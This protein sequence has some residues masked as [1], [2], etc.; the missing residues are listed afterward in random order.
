MARL[1]SQNEIISNLLDFFRI[2]Q[3]LLDT[4]PGTVARD[5]F[6]DAPSA[7]VARLYREL[8][9]VASVQSLRFALGIDLDKLADNF[10][11]RR[12]KGSKAAG[13]AV[14]TF[15]SLDSDFAINKG[16]LVTARNG[17]TFTVV[18]STIISTVFANQFKATAARLKADLDF[19]GI[20]DQYA[21]EV[22]VEATTAG[23]TGNI[24]KY[25]LSG[26]NIAGINNITNISPIGGGRLPEDDATFRNRILAVFS[27]ANTGTA[28]GYYNAAK[29]DPA[30]IDVIVIEPGDDLMV[31]DGTQ[32]VVSENGTRT[33]TADGTGGKVDVIVFGARF[34]EGLDTFIYRDKSNTGDPT[35]T[36]N[37]YVLGQISGDEN[38]TVTRR[39]LENIK[40]GTLPQQP[41]VNLVQV[42]G[43][44]SGANYVEKSVD[45][46]GRVTGNY[47]LVKD[48][49]AYA[50]SPFGFDRLRWISDRVSDFSEEKTK[51]QFNGQDPVSFTDVLKIGAA[52]QSISIINENSS[53]LPSDRSLIQLAHYPI[54][55]VTRVFNA[56]TGERYVVSNQN[57]DGGATNTTGRIKISGKSLPAVSDTLQVDYVWN[58][59]YDPYFDFDNKLV[60][61]N[62][63]TVQDSIDWGFSN[64][65]R[66]EKA[67]LTA[68]GSYLVATVTHPVSAVSSVN[69]F[70]TES[71]TVGISSGRLSVTLP[72]TVVNIVSITR[73]SD[74][75][76]LWNTS[77]SDGSFNAMTA[78]FPTD[79]AAG[80]GE[81]IDVVY[82]AIDVYNTNT[83]GNFNSNRITVVPSSDAVA[84]TIV[85]CNYISNVSEI[86]PSSAISSLPALRSGN[87]FNT[88]AATNIGNQPTSHVFSS[89]VIQSNLRQAPSNL[90]LTISGS[91]S[92]GVFTITGTTVNKVFDAVYTVSTAGLK[93]DLS[94]AIKSALKLKSSSSVSANV[95]LLKIAKVEKV[96]T[97]S[98]F[99]VLTV[100]NTFDLTGYKLQNNDFVKSESISDAS[101]GSTQFTLPSTQNNL[102]NS[103]K[104]GERIRISFYYSVTSDTENV[105]FSKSGTLYTNKKFALVDSIAVSSGFTSGA[106][107]SATLTVN[108]LNQPTTRSRYRVIY[109]YLGPKTNE[110]ITIRY[111]YDKLIGD[112]TFALENTRPI[113]ADVLA[114][115]ATAILVDV[116]MKIIVA[117]EFINSSNIVIQ[118]VKDTITN[119]INSKLGAVLD[120]SDLVNAAYSVNGVDSARVI[121]FNKSNEAG[122]VLSIKAQKNEYITANNVVVEIESR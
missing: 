104:V 15:N 73:A 50:G 40:K 54:S 39:R 84:G 30:A 61:T 65:V 69:V 111:N 100:E 80:F 2:S 112:T 27:G 9:E 81:D 77:K 47:E 44:L 87:F 14:L 83:P 106:S 7:Q 32:V 89:G 26:T 105:A 75:A 59:S 8:G 110:R 114:K 102:E 49:G 71:T 36:K 34:A 4:K 72:Q 86:L 57:P 109:D 113:N 17:A 19:V 90:A 18:N 10:S 92:P 51:T 20:T 52:T 1:R 95:K 24:S 37:D 94:S 53:V 31:R 91:I 46:L 118:N 45:S 55:T 93:Q 41:V 21:V 96:T 13:T 70:N 120:S 35:N 33:I 122:S 108:N 42:S 76:E 115:A 101:L 98:N 116:S 99:D 12:N 85:E 5:L 88:T 29:E 22:L 48:T 6:V 63:R 119:L 43:T 11:I 28:T 78:Y 107:G 16:S 117:A 97:T 121:A 103:P 64:V 68:F 60:K 23:T 79:S 66:R 62:I 74:G 3:P 67:T 25:S 38:K 58:F 82:N 56:T